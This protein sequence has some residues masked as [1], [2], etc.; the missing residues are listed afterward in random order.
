MVADLLTLAASAIIH[1]GIGGGRAE[2]ASAKT[3]NGTGT[4]TE[5]PAARRPQEGMHAGIIFH[6]HRVQDSCPSQLWT[7]SAH[8]VWSE[9]EE[10]A[11]FTLRF[12]TP[13]HGDWYILEYFHS[14]F[15]VRPGSTREISQRPKVVQ[16]TI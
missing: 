2:P 8:H 1:G 9:N 16:M 12:L 14:F 10:T 3:R 6:Q 11:H 4:G 13:R 15:M 7:S 5:D